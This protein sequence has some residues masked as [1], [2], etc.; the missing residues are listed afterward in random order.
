MSKLDLSDTTIQQYASAIDGSLTKWAVRSSIISQPL[1]NIRSQSEFDAVS[2]QI[3]QLPEF[4]KRNTKG[5]NLYSAALNKYS[6]FLASI[7]QLFSPESNYILNPSSGNKFWVNLSSG[8]IHYFVEKFGDK[9]NIVLR[10]D[11]DLQGDFYAIP[12]AIVKPALTEKYQTEDKSGRKRWVASIKNHQL[13]IRR[14]PT[15]IDVSSYYGNISALLSDFNQNSVDNEN[16]YAIENRKIEIQQRQKQSLFR[17]RVLENFDGCCC[18]TGFS[19][20]ELLIASHI[21]PWRTRIE[22]RLNPSNG[23]L[24]FA[25]Y[26]KMFDLGF[27]TFDDDLT[28]IIPS[29]LNLFSIPLQK[30]LRELDGRKANKPQK[31]PLKSDYLEFHRSEIFSKRITVL[32]NT[33]PK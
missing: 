27:F 1:R 26:D 14:Y 21:I 19:E 3:Q 6:E 31:W 17:K 12:Y 13:R 2:F 25:G 8:R 18:L 24:L 9:F 11:L 22:T 16:D 4:H 23:L 7:P 30:Q 33:Y 5:N 29:D 32:Q 28:V 20:T 15:P 10:G